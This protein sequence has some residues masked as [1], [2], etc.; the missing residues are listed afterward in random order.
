MYGGTNAPKYQ[1]SAIPD[2]VTFLQQM[3][4]CTWDNDCFFAIFPYAFGTSHLGFSSLLVKD[5][6]MMSF[7]G[8]L[9]IGVLLSGDVDDDVNATAESSA[10][11]WNA[12]LEVATYV[13]AVDVMV[14][15]SPVQAESLQ[16]LAERA[17]VDRQWDRN[18][19]SSCA[20]IGKEG[21]R[22]LGAIDGLFELLN[23]TQRTCFETYN[24]W[25]PIYRRDKFD[26]EIY[27]RELRG[28]M[29]AASQSRLSVMAEVL[30]LDEQQ[31]QNLLLI[32]KRNISRIVREKMTAQRKLQQF[33]DAVRSGVPVN[34]MDPSLA[35][36]LGKAQRH[37]MVI[38]RNVDRNWEQFLKELLTEDQK[39]Q[40]EEIEY[41]RRQRQ[42]RFVAGVYVR[43][44]KSAGLAI[45]DEQSGQL[46]DLV[47]KHLRPPFD[48]GVSR[49]DSLKALCAVP[50]RAFV[51]IIGRANWIKLRKELPDWLGEVEIPSIPEKNDPIILGSPKKKGADA[52]D[53]LRRNIND[54]CRSCDGQCLP[55]ED[56]R[57]KR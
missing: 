37:P 18:S 55:Q 43:T 46:Q 44:W 23:E 24:A 12:K 54:G 27:K 5:P 49:E 38:F 6:F 57:T 41:L 8:V 17:V 11:D 4:G 50:P 25:R 7:V 1:K 16:S 20:W 19:A 10:L 21:D 56:R 2:K 53:S 29:T 28:Q 32:G 35:T 9:T 22:K 3:E 13:Q 36:S 14:Y 15:L 52:A 33:I 42:A 45:D 30:R 31:Q 34:R 39:Q 48:P 51:N 40:L 26:E 47:A